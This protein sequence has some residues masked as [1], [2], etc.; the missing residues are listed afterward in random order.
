MMRIN[1][2]FEALDS[3]YPYK[4]ANGSYYFDT[5][6]GEQYKVMI[7]GDK[8][9]E[10]SFM[11][12]GEN[13]QPKDN[14]TGA[15]DSR[16]VFGT[17]INIVKEYIGQHNP[18]IL[19][20]AAV[21]SEPSRV[22]LYKMLAAQ[23]DKALPGYSFAKTLKNGVFSV[24]YLTRDNIQVPKM[25]TVKNTAHKALDAVFED[26]LNE[27]S[28]QGSQCTKDCSGHAAGYSWSMKNG[29]VTAATPSPSFDK[30]TGIASD[31]V[32]N[33]R[34]IRPKVRDA[35]GKFAAPGITPKV[36]KPQNPGTIP[37]RGPTATP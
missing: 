15:G 9:A 1:E 13:D 19:M 36:S 11:A 32:A 33:K 17:V 29:G 23:A 7:S 25:D 3:S 34:V 8:K 30:G 12:R 6:A 31:Q 16:K 20:F 18:E 21:N 37:S 27:L 2:L 24:F 5:D 10:V 22:R 28:F 14:I 26:M 4:F 35:R